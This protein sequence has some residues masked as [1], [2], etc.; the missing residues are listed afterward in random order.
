MSRLPLTVDFAALNSVRDVAV[1][2]G[3]SE[4]L[5]ERAINN[6]WETSKDAKFITFRGEVVLTLPGEQDL[7]FPVDLRKKNPKRRGERRRVWVVQHQEFANA[8]KALLRRLNDYLNQRLVDFPSASAHGYIRGRSIVTNAAAHLGARMI[9][10]GDIKN[11]FPSISR[12]RVSASLSSAG[13]SPSAA[14]IL[15]RFVTID[16]TLPL[17]LNASPLIANLVCRELDN[18]MTELAN[19]LECAY[20]RYADDFTFSSNERLPTREE[21]ASIV[22]AQG[23]E[24]SDKKFRVSKRG[25][26]HYVTGLSVADHKQPRLRKKFKRRLRQEL[27]FCEKYG[28]ESHGAA[29]NSSVPQVVNRIDGRI[30]YARGIEPDFGGALRP[31]WTKL[32]EKESLTPRYPPSYERAPSDV[33]VVFDESELETVGGPLFCMC[34]VTIEDPEGVR[35]QIQELFSRHMAD[36]FSPGRKHH[37]ATRGFHHTDDPE[38]VRTSFIKLLAELPIRGFL[39]YGSKPE[40]MSYA[41][42]YHQVFAWLLKRRFFAADRRTVHV[43]YEE[44][45]NVVHDKLNALMVQLFLSLEL[46][47]SRRPR[48]LPTLKRASKADEPLLAVPDYL[49]GVFG[50]YALSE[51]TPQR[52]ET[53]TKRFERLR[54]RFRLIGSLNAGVHYS[55]HHPFHPW[56]GGNPT[57]T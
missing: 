2:I 13:L 53:V 8:Q 27:Y 33:L 19:R 31:K 29:C 23:F 18:A 34:C 38:D 46:S 5:V 15:A 48:D 20:T 3:C 44:N 45:P 10:S 55:R 32:L 22:E 7:C 24:L 28:I 37:M 1:A 12:A 36:P 16:G 49:L 57:G 47:G 35:T 40:T 52:R 11:F 4:A 26:R 56:P 25:Q 30:A 21:L 39:A 6:R 50:A 51:A 43:M 9:L 41:N 17:G 14:D 42:A 54:D